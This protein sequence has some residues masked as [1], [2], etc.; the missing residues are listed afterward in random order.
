MTPALREFATVTRV[1]IPRERNR[2]EWISAGDKRA[3]FVVTIAGRTV[4]V[5][6]RGEIEPRVKY[7][8]G[9][10]PAMSP[11]PRGAKEESDE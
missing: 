8:I 9:V 5:M 6:G 2:F 1:T 3:G 4:V 11:P 10:D 7:A